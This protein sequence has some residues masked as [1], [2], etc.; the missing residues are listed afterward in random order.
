MLIVIT[1]KCGDLMLHSVRHKRDLLRS[2]VPATNETC[3][4]N[5]VSSG[6]EDLWLMPRKANQAP[7]LSCA[8][9]TAPNGNYGS[10]PLIHRY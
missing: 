1:V 8:T 10:S 5:Q 6:L 9:R 2:R 7:R 3:L 4:A